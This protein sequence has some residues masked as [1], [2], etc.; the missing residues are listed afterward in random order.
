M[1]TI[2]RWSKN[3]IDKIMSDGKE[4]TLSEIISA[5]WDEIED[6]NKNPRLTTR[7]TG[8][9]IP[10]RGQLK[11]HFSVGRQYFYPHRPDFESGEFDTLTGSRRTKRSNHTVKKY[12]CKT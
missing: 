6:S 2:S 12:W 9:H 4:R 3:T 11:K 10:T 8:R 5:M 1:K 7:R